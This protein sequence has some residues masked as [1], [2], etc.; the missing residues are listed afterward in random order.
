MNIEMETFKKLKNQIEQAKSSALQ[1]SILSESQKNYALELIEREFLESMNM[2]LEANEE[3]LKQ[4]E[5]E[6]ISSA[7]I[8]RLILNPQRITSMANGIRNVINSKDPIGKVLDGWYHSKGMKITKIRVPLGVIGVIYEARPNVT[9]DS[10]ALAIKSGNAIVLRGSQQAWQT[11]KAI[12][13]VVYKALADSQVPINAIQYLNDKTRESTKVL[14]KAVNEVDLIIPRGGKELKNFVQEHSLVPVLGA[15]GG[16]C[17]V[18]IDEHADIEKAVEI[19]HN[20]KV[21]RP[22]VCNACETILIHRDIYELATIP[23]LDRLIKS[24]VEIIG[25]KDILKLFPL[26]TPATDED[27]SCEYLDLKVSI[28]VVDSML[29]AIDHINSYSTGHSDAIVTEAIEEAQIFTRMVDSGVVYV[30]ASTRFTDGEEFG[31]GAEIGISTQKLHAR[32]PIGLNELC[33]YKYII[34]GSG[35]IR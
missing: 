35:Q 10:I 1:M 16:L 23:L 27:W 18:Y 29:E 17:H 2:I 12:M 11:N 15:G 13:Q 30:N 9:T 5:E 31:F 34:E 6:G 19:A 21:Q 20:S 25:D 32:G 22:G 33:S 28:K 3:D 7:L 4:A 26:A 14:L 8:D 24:N